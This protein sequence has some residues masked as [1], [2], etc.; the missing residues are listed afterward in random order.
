[1][2][3]QEQFTSR[4]QPVREPPIIKENDGHTNG[5]LVYYTFGSYPQGGGGTARSSLYYGGN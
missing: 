4:P 3:T 5:G 1:M 2:D